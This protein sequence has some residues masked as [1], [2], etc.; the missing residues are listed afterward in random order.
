MRAQSLRQREEAAMLDTIIGPE[1]WGEIEDIE[2][3]LCFSSREASV[4]SVPFASLDMWGLIH[5]VALSQ[6]EHDPPWRR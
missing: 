2:S 6:A 1:V 5:K 4:G 3:E